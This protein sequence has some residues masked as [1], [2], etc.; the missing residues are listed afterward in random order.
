MRLGRRNELRFA[1]LGQ[2]LVPAT[3]PVTSGSGV[4]ER[5]N[6]R[7]V[8]ARPL[9]GLGELLA[10]DMLPIPCGRQPRLYR[11][12]TL[13]RRQ[14]GMVRL[15]QQRRQ[16][17]PATRHRTR[18]SRMLLQGFGIGAG[19]EGKEP[20]KARPFLP[21]GSTPFRTSP[22]GDWG[23]KGRESRSHDSRSRCRLTHRAEGFTH[24]RSDQISISSNL[25]SAPGTP[26]TI[27]P[28][29]VW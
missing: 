24:T 3:V 28:R 5:V 23:S 4:E 16:G 9:V 29:A 20:G 19:R 6:L 2:G 26:S 13:C 15:D 22:Q 7:L 1:N 18:R 11:S 10:A 8:I 17:H 12:C 27:C 21:S 14:S 25:S